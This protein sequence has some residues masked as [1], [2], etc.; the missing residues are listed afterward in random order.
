MKEPIQ[1]A[2]KWIKVTNLVRVFDVDAET[3]LLEY[4]PFRFDDL[5]LE[6]NVIL[7]QDHWLYCPAT[8]SREV[9]LSK[10]N[11]STQANHTQ[12]STATLT[13]PVFQ[14]SPKMH[15]N[16]ASIVLHSMS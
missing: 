4:S 6:G 13:L 1:L 14:T 12:P 10:N 7:V 5:C 2:T 3:Q 11:T 9:Q 8:G 16:L 15:L